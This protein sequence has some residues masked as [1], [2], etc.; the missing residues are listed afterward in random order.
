MGDVGDVTDEGKRL[1]AQARKAA[2][3]APIK[4]AA[5]EKFE[6]MVRNPNFDTKLAAIYA[7]LQGSLTTEPVGTACATREP[8]WI[9][10]ELAL[11]LVGC[12]V[13]VQ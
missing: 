1:W 8:K 9:K 3:T 4:L 7:Q 6:E 2:R 5:L 11:L 10:A 13:L 12:V